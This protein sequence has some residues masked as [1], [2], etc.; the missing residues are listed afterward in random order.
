VPDQAEGQIKAVSDLAAAKAGQAQLKHF[1]GFG[2]RPTQLD[3]E[4]VEPVRQ[5][6][7]R[8]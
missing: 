6:V 2:M 7:W 5:R 4:P 1:D 3:R 8:S